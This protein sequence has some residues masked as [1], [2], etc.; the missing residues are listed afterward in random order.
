M[1]RSKQRSAIAGW[2]GLFALAIQAAL[3][4]LVA[5]EISLAAGAG[6]DSVFELCEYRHLHAVAPHDA[7]DAPGKSH[8]HDGDDGALCP[9]CI[10]LHAGSVFTAPAILALPLPAVR[11]IATALPQMRRAPPPVALTA[12]RSRA[13]PIG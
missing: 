3:P 11:E 10:A 12:Y 5:V 7:D 6:K 13:P 2:L 4:L 1:R 8:H 9:I